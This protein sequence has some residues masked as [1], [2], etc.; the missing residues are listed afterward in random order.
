MTAVEAEPGR[1]VDVTTKPQ[2]IGFLGLA[3]MLE[4]GGGLT[5]LGPQFEARVAR[6][7]TDAE[8]LLDLSTLIF[9]TANPDYRNLAFDRQQRALQLRQV[10]HLAPPANPASLELLVL[11]APGD[12]TSNTPVDC[13]LEGADINV[14]LLYVL[15]D[16]PLPS[17]LPDHDVIFV[18]IGESS[19]NQIL[20]HQLGELPTLTA[21]PVVNLPDRIALLTRDRVSE[22]LKSVPGAV[23]PAT[24]MAKRQD[25][26]KVQ[27]REMS[28]DEIMAGGRFPIIVR[29]PDS[30]GGKDLV[31]VDGVEDLGAYL[32]RLPNDEFYISNF[33]DYSSRDG[34][35]RKYRVVQVQGRPFGCHLAI[36]SNWMIHYVNAN[37]DASAA[38]RKEEEDFFAR[39]DDEF[40]VKHRE[41]LQSIHEKVGLDY[42]GIDCAETPDGKLLVF[43]V[44]NAAIV[45]AFDDPALYPYKPAAMRKIFTAFRAMLAGRARG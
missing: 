31:K 40:A 13:L 26:V 15:P 10:Y 30:Q 42:L 41:S 5:V 43:E 17:P 14:T 12:M 1:T 34:Q 36:S 38:K 3:R 20:L 7:A 28:L 39:F 44:D 35:F 45:H 16:R 37:M 4:A 24:V 22:L 19:A 8:A 21:K 23:M 11:M 29:P 25:L 2:L 6:D 32:A 18:A 27:R 9:F 33:I